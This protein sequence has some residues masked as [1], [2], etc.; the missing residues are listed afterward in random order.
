MSS[1]SSMPSLLTRQLAETHLS[2][3]NFLESRST[4]PRLLH[5]YTAPIFEYGRTSGLTRFIV[6][7]LTELAYRPFFFLK[8][9]PKSLS[10]THVETLSYG[11]DPRQKILLLTPQNYHSSHPPTSSNKKTLLIFTHGG[12]W[13][14]G[15]PSFYLP[16]L[17]TYASLGYTVA[18]LGYR[19]YPTSTVSGQ[20]SD[21]HSAYLHL[22]H[23]F[24]DLPCILSGH[25][26]GSHITLLTILRYDL[27]V[28]FLGLSG[29]YDML[30]HFRYES[31]RGLEIL[32]GLQPAGG[33]INDNLELNSMKGSLTGVNHSSFIFVHGLEDFTVPFTQSYNASYCLKNWGCDSRVVYL[34]KCDHMGAVIELMKGCGERWL[35]NDIELT[36]KL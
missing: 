34:D 6:D 26:S 19:T 28:T 16:L 12:A 15:S 10:R 1:S 18:L 32:S 20:V 9:G 11:P 30:S 4:I 7:G 33:Y 3:N 21:V 17:S 2:N 22:T 35:K 27:K 5:P 14:S 36:S 31:K 24:P 8:F 13:G 23:L 29:V 25:S